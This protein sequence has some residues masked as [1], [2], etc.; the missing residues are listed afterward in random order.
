MHKKMGRTKHRSLNQNESFPPTI[1][2]TMTKRK[3]EIPLKLGELEKDRQDIQER[4]ER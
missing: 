3:N 2:N 4:Q 1:T